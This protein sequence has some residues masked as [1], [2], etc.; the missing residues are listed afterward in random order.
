[1]RMMKTA[2]FL[3]ACV[4][5]APL[6]ASA[7]NTIPGLATTLQVGQ[8][9]ID[10]NMD[11][12]NQGR[13]YKY[14]VFQGRSYGVEGITEKAP[15]STSAGG[16]Q[17]HV[18]RA[19]ATTSLGLSLNSSA[20]PGGGPQNPGRV[21]YFAPAS[22]LNFM[23]VG[24]Y[25]F[26]GTVRSY[27]WRVVETTQFCPWFFSGNGFEAFILVRNTT[28]KPLRVIVTLRDTAGAVLGTRVAIV[29]ANASFNSQVSDPA[30]FNLPSASGNVEIAYGPDNPGSD[31]G[32]PGAVIANVTSL[33]FGLG[34]SFDTPAGPRVD[35]SR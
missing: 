30:G 18:Y 27:R 8:G 31:G 15:T 12:A 5:M 32:G 24:N 28:Y 34:V 35:Y 3:G 2:L 16:G 17:T 6:T 10:V 14:Q 1:M 11:G 33:S 13:F 7:Q 29:Q 21:C 19:D 26:D 4:V 22:E 23:L 25:P 9:W 20:E